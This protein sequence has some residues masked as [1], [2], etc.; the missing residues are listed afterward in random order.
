MRPRPIH[1]NGAMVRAIL[2]GR[3]NQ[4]RRVV[5][6]Q[7]D[8]ELDGGPY[9]NV[10]GFRWSPTA[11]N[12]IECPYGVPEDRIWVRETHLF[13]C[14]G[15][16]VIYR[17]DYPEAEAWGL[18]AMYGGWKP[19]MFMPRAACRIWLEVT[20]VRMERLREI[21]DADAIDEGVDAMASDRAVD[22][23][24]DLWEGIYGVGSWKRNPWVWVVSFRMMG[25][26]E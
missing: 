4:T 21:T 10:G 5:A 25:G 6:P 13:R 1:F 2:E 23:Y 12:P 8:G 15:R 9:W 18:G 14:S 19:P 26:E 16:I 3:K 20:G 22:A 7:P 11:E 17:A 24:A